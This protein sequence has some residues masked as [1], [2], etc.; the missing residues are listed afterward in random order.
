MPDDS[1]IED[2]RVAFLAARVVYTTAAS[3]WREGTLAFDDVL[4]AFGR[5]SHLTARCLR[6]AASD[7][8]A[9]RF[10]DE[11][12]VGGLFDPTRARKALARERSPAPSR[13]LP[14]VEHGLG[15]LLVSQSALRDVDRR[16]DDLLE[17]SGIRRYVEPGA[18]EDVKRAILETDAFKEAVVS[19]GH[20]EW[21]PETYE[22]L[23][24]WTTEARAAAFEL[25]YGP[26]LDR[27]RL[28]RHR[29]ETAL[30]RSADEVLSRL[31]SGRE[32]LPSSAVA[33]Y[34]GAVLGQTD[35]LTGDAAR[36][37]LNE[38]VSRVVERVEARNEALSETAARRE[39]ERA[40]GLG[41]LAELRDIHRGVERVAECLR[42]PAALDTDVSER[43]AIDEKV[44][45]SPTR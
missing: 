12:V 10:Y 40:T 11:H 1:T 20:R 27:E 22:N 42:S 39:A 2:T 13:V 44:V 25:G 31:H 23:R 38:H 4:D 36:R 16:L 43:R 17:A 30:G 5:L 19:F 33:L 6:E 3:R 28:A 15:E 18:N 26:A 37:V 8:E 7:D 32:R 45:L 35:R 41:R 14:F 34:V 29:F 9:L 21:T 24:G